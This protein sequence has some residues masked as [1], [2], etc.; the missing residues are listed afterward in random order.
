[1]RQHIRQP[2]LADALGL[3]VA[4]DLLVVLDDLGDDEG[5]ELLGE[6]RVEARFL[7]QRSQARYL[8][9]LAPGIGWR[10]VQLGLEQPHLLSAAEA[11]SQKM[12]EGGVEV[13]DGGAI[14]GQLRGDAITALGHAVRLRSP[15]LAVD[16]SVPEPAW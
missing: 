3:V 4:A 5:E 16:R 14:D 2:G 6:D 12:D 8:L 10:Q 7:G 13:V 1:M 15:A 9:A 11:L